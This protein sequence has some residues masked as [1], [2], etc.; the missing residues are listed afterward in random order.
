MVPNLQGWYESEEELVSVRT[1][2]KMWEKRRQFLRLERKTG[3]VEDTFVP[4]NFEVRRGIEGT[5]QIEILIYLH[6]H[7]VLLVETVRS[8]C[9]TDG[10]DGT[11]CSKTTKCDQKSWSLGVSGPACRGHQ[12]QNQSE[13]RMLGSGNEQDPLFACLQTLKF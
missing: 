8:C 5:S 7:G 1:S 13:R 6:V 12:R 3:T 11:R 2:I 9:A 4:S 10:T